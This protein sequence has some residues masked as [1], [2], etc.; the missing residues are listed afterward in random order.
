MT[1][2][3]VLIPVLD[4]PERAAT[5]ADSVVESDQRAR[6]VFL[7]SPGDDAEIAAVDATGHASVVVP[8]PVGR[9]DWARKNNLGIRLVEDEWVLLGADDLRFHPGWFDACLD[10]AYRTDACVVGTNDMGNS[11]VVAG[12]HSTHPLV[13]RD[14]LGCGTIDEDGKILHEGYWHNY[15]DDEF[16]QTAQ[17]RGTFAPARFAYVEHLHPNWGK[18]RDDATYRR[19]LER[20]DDDRR[21]YEQRKRLWEP[22]W[23]SPSRR[24]G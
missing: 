4:R 20:F 13:H 18:G 7:C 24:R 3:A 11:R 19:G 10:V 21:L 9:G 14:Y 12:N 23:R 1:S 8:W 15:V 17:A 22:L 6:P 16:V 2:V 5:V